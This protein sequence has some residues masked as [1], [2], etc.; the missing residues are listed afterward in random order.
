MPIIPALRRSAGRSCIRDQPR[1][2]SETLAP[3]KKKKK[4]ITCSSPECTGCAKTFIAALFIITRK[5]ETRN[6]VS[7]HLAKEGIIKTMV[8]YTVCT[9]WSR[10]IHTDTGR[11]QDTWF[12]IQYNT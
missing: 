1:L 11:C 6:I 9:K 4:V 3:K 12:K 7:V 2:N 10:S 8:F 5:K